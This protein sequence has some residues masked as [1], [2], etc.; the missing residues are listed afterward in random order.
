M[1]FLVYQEHEGIGLVELTHLIIDHV[2]E[3]VRTNNHR[4]LAVDVYGH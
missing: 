3:E 2:K 4:K 1:A